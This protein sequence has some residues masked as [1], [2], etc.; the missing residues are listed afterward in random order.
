MTETQSGAPPAK[1]T[2]RSE[3]PGSTRITGNAS[4]ADLSDAVVALCRAM[5]DHGR[6]VG[7]AQAEEE[8]AREW[9][10]L[11]RK[12]V[13]DQAQ[14]DRARQARE[15]LEVA[16]PCQHPGGCDGWHVAHYRA[17]RAAV[18]CHKHQPKRWCPEHRDNDRCGYLAQLQATQRPEYTG[19][20]VE[21]ETTR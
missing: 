20:P 3:E 5:F 7:R 1:E 13:D 12:V 11:A 2:R 6:D 21:W 10:L 15:G 19:G 9:H 16:L 17:D 4:V 8:M 18:R 14:A